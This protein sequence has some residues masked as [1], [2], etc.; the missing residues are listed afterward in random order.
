MKK[1]VSFLIL[2]TGLFF[3]ISVSASEIIAE[4]NNLGGFVGHLGV[5]SSNILY[6]SV[7][8]NNV[9]VY[10]VNIPA[11]PTLIGVISNV[12]HDRDV[13]IDINDNVWIAGGLAG[14]LTINTDNDTIQFV[15]FNALENVNGI[16]SDGNRVFSANYNDGFG[17]FDSGSS[18]WEH[19]TWNTWNLIGYDNIL[20][21]LGQNPSI[22]LWDVS[23]GAPEYRGSLTDDINYVDAAYHDGLLYVAMR[24]EGIA[25]ID[26][27]DPTNPHEVLRNNTLNNVMGVKYNDGKLYVASTDIYVL[28]ADTLEIIETIP[29]S[30]KSE[31]ICLF[32]NNKHLAVANGE[33]SFAII[34]LSNN[35]GNDECF[36]QTDLDAQY[37]AGMQYCIDHPEECGI[38]SQSA[39]LNT[40]TK[41]LDIP[42]V[43]VGNREFEFNMQQSNQNTFKLIN[44]TSK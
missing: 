30:G 28:D 27:N 31:D 34:E 17:E 39:T 21:S 6:V 35:E 2:L 7:L 18:L 38:S 19:D 12:G 15:A 4:K 24:W 37:A 33:G 8:F 5:T 23:N 41:I 1:V 44:V 16:W 22:G 42:S 32:N 10:D 26:V 9:M 40:Q 11:N 3:S 29:T 13:F 25:I 36:T 43:L 20:V 14:A